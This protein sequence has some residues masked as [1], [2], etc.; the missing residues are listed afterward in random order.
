MADFPVALVPYNTKF[1]H[2]A[3]LG[4]GGNSISLC[5]KG[6]AKGVQGEKELYHTLK[7]VVRA[8][9]CGS[10]HGKWL[11]RVDITS[12]SGNSNI[13]TISGRMALGNTA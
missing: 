12:S 11:V 9:I 10:R 1:L 2:G 13:D 3:Q 4:C 5:S 6:S 8:R 7:S